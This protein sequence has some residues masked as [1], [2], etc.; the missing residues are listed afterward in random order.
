[1]PVYE[2]EKD[3]LP[4]GKCSPVSGHVTWQVGEGLDVRPLL[5]SWPAAL[6]STIRD[7]GDFSWSDE[8]CVSVTRTLLLNAVNPLVN[9][10]RQQLEVIS[11]SLIMM[12]LLRLLIR[13]ILTATELKI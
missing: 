5:Q 10:M 8:D 1:M 7:P 3:A 12:Q 6:H 13:I 2:L 11:I 4:P 9:S